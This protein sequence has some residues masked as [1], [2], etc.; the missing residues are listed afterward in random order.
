MGGGGGGEIN[1][2]SYFLNVG[3][4]WEENIFAH[5]YCFAQRGRGVGGVG[6]VRL[7]VE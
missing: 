3:E 5:N 6:A 2:L 7:L 1:D 4:L